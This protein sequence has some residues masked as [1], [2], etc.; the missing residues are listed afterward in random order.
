MK[1]CRIIK[2]QN[3]YTVRGTNFMHHSDADMYAS[4]LANVLNN[5]QIIIYE[6]SHV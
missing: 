3:G 2:T 4:Y 6:Y 5:V 1:K